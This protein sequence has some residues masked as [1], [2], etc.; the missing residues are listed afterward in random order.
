[1]NRNEAAEFIQRNIMGSTEAQAFLMVNRRR[2]SALVEAGKLTPI[3]KL[4]GENLFFLADLVQLKHQLINDPRSN[5]Y[6]NTKN[7]PQN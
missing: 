5:L 3:K 4:K 2:L 6:K 1:M 7:S